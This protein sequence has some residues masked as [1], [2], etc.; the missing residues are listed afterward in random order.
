MDELTTWLRERPKWTQEAVRK[1]VLNGKLTDADLDELLESCKDENKSS[2]KIKHDDVDLTTFGTSSSESLRIISIGDIK[3]INALAPKKPLEFG[4]NNNISIVYGK[5]GSGKSGYVRI[6]KHVC[7]ARNIGTLHPNIF[8]DKNEQDECLISY[9]INNIKKSIKWSSKLG[10]IKDLRSVDIFDSLCGRMYLTNESQVTYEPPL[11]SLFSELIETCDKLNARLSSEILN[12]PSKKPILPSELALT[13]TGKWYN[14]LKYN[15]DITEV[16][17]HCSWNKDDEKELETLSKRLAE[18]SPME[19]AAKLRKQKSHIESLV[20]NTKELFKKLSDSR[21]VEILALRDDLKQKKEIQELAATKLFSDVPLDGVGSAIWQELWE[22]A[23]CV[24]CEQLLSEEAKI[25]LQDFENFIKSEL[26]GAARLAQGKLDEA[27]QNIGE[28][29]SVKDLHIKLDAAGINDENLVS[30]IVATY[31]ILS[32][33][34]EELQKDKPS[35]TPDKLPEIEIKWLQIMEKDDEK[36][37]NKDEFSDSWLAI[38]SQRGAQHEEDAKLYDADAKSDNREEL[39]KKQLEMRTKK[40]LCDQKKSIEDEIT[41]LNTIRKLKEAQALVSTGIYSTKKGNLAEILITEAFVNRFNSELKA[42]GTKNIKVEIVKTRTEKGKV[43]H[44]IR[45]KGVKGY[46]IEEILSEGEYRIVCLAAFLADVEKKSNVSPFVFDDPISSLDQDYE[47]A[48]A[49]KLIDMAK[50]RQV[51]IFTHRLSLLGFIEYYTEKEGL[52]SDNIYVRYESWGAGEPG[53]TPL[54]VKQPIKA[55]NTIL[56]ERIPEAKNLLNKE[57]YDV[58]EPYAKSICIDFRII[59]E[60][61]IENYLLAD[62]VR[63][64]RRAI[65]TIGKIDK[66]A[67]INEKD[68]KYIDELMSKYSSYQ[69]SQSEET[70]VSLPDADEIS[71]DMEELKLWYE[72]FKKR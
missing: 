46:P 18:T 67:K 31:N 42:L 62:V 35:L 54:F 3:G 49:R 16:N 17:K 8:S 53:I 39:T 71:G 32:K 69:H 61:F 72:E 27:I 25:R 44:Q 65:T 6:L 2:V 58:Y 59:I 13:E 20:N 66:L 38:L 64:N 56:N 68:C 63:R 23:R 9:E 50:D 21:Y 52:E 70:P 26:K 48:M 12:N 43:L 60:R 19:Q 4:N 34:N 10:F 11:L 15:T 14:Q 24:L 55:L 36:N 1:L 45:L 37:S 5:N 33:R 41:R 30:K 47:E 7:G 51:L 22:K 28:I 40:W 57:G 29:T